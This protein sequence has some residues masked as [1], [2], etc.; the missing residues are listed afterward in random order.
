MQFIVVDD[1]RKVGIAD[2]CLIEYDG[3]TDVD[4]V[5]RN[6]MQLNGNSEIGS[7]AICGK[8]TNGNISYVINSIID[9]GEEDKILSI[10]TIYLVVDN[11]SDA[12]FNKLNENLN[13]PIVQTVYHSFGI[14]GD[15]L[16]EQFEEF[17]SHLRGAV[18][19]RDYLNTLINERGYE[20]YSEVYKAAG[21]SKYTF[22]KILNFNK[23]HKPSKD[24]VAALTIGLKLNLDDAQKLYHSA[25]FHLGT[26]DLVDRVIRFFIS[27]SRYD[28]DEV[29]YC[30]CCYEHPILGEK[31]R[32]SVKF[33]ID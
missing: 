20:K 14:Q 17:D 11:L 18:K 30:L 8:L 7:I 16:K 12:V 5:I 15:S 10:D 29:N 13:K 1:I 31:P 6:F 32:D 9:C 2:N 27:E 19:F 28:I 25:G 22:S 26:T 23:E 3:E 33:G 24:T 4:F 21:I